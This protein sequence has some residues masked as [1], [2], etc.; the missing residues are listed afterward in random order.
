MENTL[1]CAARIYREECTLGQIHKAAN[2][3]EY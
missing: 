2:Q 1:K 3:V